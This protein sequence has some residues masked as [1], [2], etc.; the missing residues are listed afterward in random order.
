[1]SRL[2]SRRLSVFH[3]QFVPGTMPAMAPRKKAPPTVPERGNAGKVAAAGAVLAAGAAAIPHIEKLAKAVR[4]TGVG[5][6]TSGALTRVGHR[7]NARRYADQIGGRY[8]FVQLPDGARWIVFQGDEPK[9]SFPTQSGDL[10]E[11]LQ[12]IKLDRLK[13]KQP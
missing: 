4:S 10:A 11:A 8:A 7:R 1:M 9:A 2:R 13:F 5:K 6:G 3:L 12:D